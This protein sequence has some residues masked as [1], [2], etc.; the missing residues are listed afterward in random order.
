MRDVE[1]MFHFQRR[2]LFPDGVT[3]DLVVNLSDKNPIRRAAK[4][5][6]HPLPDIL[7]VPVPGRHFG[8]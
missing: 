4:G 7:F 1:G 3:C 5:G 8:I 6:M 2:R